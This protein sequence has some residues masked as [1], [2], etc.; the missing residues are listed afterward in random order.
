MKLN[1]ANQV[2]AHYTETLF[3][4]FVQAGEDCGMIASN[5]FNFPIVVEGE[6]GWVEITVKVTKD[7]GDDGYGKR[8]EYRMK[9][10]EREAF[11]ALERAE[12]KAKKI[13]RDKKAREER[14]RA[15]Q[16]GE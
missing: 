6:E 16:E 13:E 7:G 9:C 8:D 4:Q 3:N 14:K 11:F 12:A 10:D 15:K 1:L 2:R 5:A